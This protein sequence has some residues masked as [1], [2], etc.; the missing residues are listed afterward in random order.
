MIEFKNMALVTFN[1]EGNKEGAIYFQTDRYKLIE[2]IRRI[3]IEYKNNCCKSDN[4]NVS[5]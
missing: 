1:W 2:K 4:N 3:Y 5:R